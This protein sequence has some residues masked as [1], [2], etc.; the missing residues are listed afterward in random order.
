MNKKATEDQFNELH[1]LVTK[2][3]LARIKS[4]E[5]TTQ[6]LKAACDWLKTNDMNGVAVEGSPLSKLAGLMPEIDPELV[7]N[8]LYGKR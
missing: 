1:N 6:D 4:G 3:F 2:E 5:A 8:R 7:Q